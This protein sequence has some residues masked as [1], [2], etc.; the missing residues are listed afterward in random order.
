MQS[1]DIFIS[2][3][4]LLCFQ[5]IPVWYIPKGRILK[6][7]EMSMLSNST[8]ATRN[9]SFCFSLCIWPFLKRSILSSISP[10][11]LRLSYI[12]VIL[13]H[14][15]HAA[16][17]DACW[18]VSYFLLPSSFPDHRLPFSHPTLKLWGSW[19]QILKHPNLC[20]EWATSL[21]RSI[22]SS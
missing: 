7:T 16:D 22:I 13:M 3:Q 14:F 12:Q 6:G 11:R 9:G 15:W 21:E 4:I 20:L 1:R 19:I 8:G 5:A 2:W 10:A 17:N 18:C